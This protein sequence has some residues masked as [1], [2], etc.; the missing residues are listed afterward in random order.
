MIAFLSKLMSSESCKNF[1]FDNIHTIEGKCLIAVLSKLIGLTILFGSIIIKVPQIVVLYRNWSSIG[2]NPLSILFETISGIL[3]I[4]YCRINQFE[5]I[6]YGEIISLFFQN[7]IILYLILIINKK[8]QQIIFLTSSL[9][10]VFSFLFVDIFTK[11][12]IYVAYLYLTFPLSM[13]GKLL[14]L[15]TLFK[16]GDARNY[17]IFTSLLMPIGSVAR[18]CTT[19]V[20]HNDLLMI[21]SH[22]IPAILNF[23]MLGLCVKYSI[24]SKDS[25]R[26]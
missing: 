2:I 11:E 3:L 16:S 26:I 6:S 4:F 21:I 19:I 24:N 18:I 5:L 9:V 13:T 8:S 7:V 17:S 25:K 1:Q 23:C 10:L 22:T 14:Q 12:F 20:E 15:Y